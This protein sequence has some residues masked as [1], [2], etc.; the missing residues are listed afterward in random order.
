MKENNK[1]KRKARFYR[2]PKFRRSASIPWNLVGECLPQTLRNI[3]PQIIIISGITFEV[4]PVPEA[5]PV[6]T[7]SFFFEEEDLLH[8]RLE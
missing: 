7:A 3:I 1:E 2:G 4:N 6:R 8:R 5:S